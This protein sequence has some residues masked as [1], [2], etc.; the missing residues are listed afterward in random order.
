MVIC[1]SGEKLFIRNIFK[2]FIFIEIGGGVVNYILFD[3]LFIWKLWVFF[4]DEYFF[5]ENGF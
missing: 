5:L 1:L 4:L 2:I 3:K